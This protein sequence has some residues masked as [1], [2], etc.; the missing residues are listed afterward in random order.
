MSGMNAILDGRQFFKYFVQD[1]SGEGKE[2][3]D[4]NISH[5]L[6]I[7]KEIPE[8]Q[9]GIQCVGWTDWPRKFMNWVHYA[10]SL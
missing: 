8:D 2:E 10:T 3:H 5:F 6:Y 1:F 9:R 7:L 4:K